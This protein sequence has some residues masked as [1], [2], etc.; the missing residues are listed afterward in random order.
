MNAGDADAGRMF[1]PKLEVKNTRCLFCLCS[2][3]VI[4]YVVVTV[5]DNF[6]ISVFKN[7][8]SY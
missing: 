7:E 8:I 4:I 3:I 6:L 2:I 5:F 1:F